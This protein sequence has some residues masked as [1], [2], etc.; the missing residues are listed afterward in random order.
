MNPS[1]N[2]QAPGIY[3]ESAQ[4]FIE[5]GP[6]GISY[7]IMNTGN[8]FQAVVIYSFPNRMSETELKEILLSNELL[9][10]HYLKTHIFWSFPESILVPPELVNDN[11]NIEM[12][13]LVYGDA[14]DGIIKS[15][16]LYKHNLHH[17]YRIP[18]TIRVS[19]SAKFP[20]ATQSHQ[21][22]LLV[23]RNFKKEDE[24]F[25]VFYTNHLT[26]MLCKE[27]LLQLIQDFEYTSPDDSVYHLLNACKSFDVMPNKVLLH[28]S[29]LIDERSGLYAAIYKYFLNV[30]LD[31]FRSD[32][33]YIEEIKDHP[34]HFFSHL[35]FQASCV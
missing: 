3:T 25:V 27:G 1:F 29:G 11:S 17:I 28:I 4:L 24:L 21:Y 7:V 31:K 15:D 12:L 5:A 20:N 19:L 9:Q 10:Q 34:A 32:F 33:S 16:F 26:M 22:S 13:N 30:E 6:M 23:N 14:T 2:I 8:F 18:E 35:F